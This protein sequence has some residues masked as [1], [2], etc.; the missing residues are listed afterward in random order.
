MERRYLVVPGLR[1]SRVMIVD[2]KPDPTRPRVIKTIDAAEIARKS[3]YSRPQTS[4]GIWATT[5]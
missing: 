3:G 4:G 5:P 2:T 1:S